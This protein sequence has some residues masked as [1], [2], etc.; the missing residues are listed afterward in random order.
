MDSFTGQLLL[1]QYRVERLLGQGG[2]AKVYLADQI[3]LNRKAA[4][5]I[6]EG[7]DKKGYTGA[8]FA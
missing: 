5:K 2:M 3:G 8:M 6:L 4:I 1:G 7:E